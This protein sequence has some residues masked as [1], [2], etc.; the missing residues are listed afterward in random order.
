MAG[1]SSVD[2]TVFKSEI[3]E[4]VQLWIVWLMTRRFYAPPL[5]PNILQILQADKRVSREPP[6][7]KNSA[8]CAAFNLV[9]QEAKPD[10]RLPFLYVFLKAYRPA[11]IK[12]LANELGIDRDTVYQ[13][14]HSAAEKF[15][16][17]SKALAEMNAQ[18]SREI[19]DYLD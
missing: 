8:L 7:A 11:P 4:L 9:I 6:D 19:E 16:R 18:V 5:P 3:E 1:D 13:R 12:V 14:A 10:E 2:N 17:Q 15:L